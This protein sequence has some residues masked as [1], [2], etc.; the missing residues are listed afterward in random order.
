MRINNKNSFSVCYIYACCISECNQDPK[1]KKNTDKERKKRRYLNDMQFFF[2]F[3]LSPHLT[4]WNFSSRHSF[5]IFGFWLELMQRVN[6]FKMTLFLSEFWVRKNESIEWSQFFKV[7]V[8]C[9]VIYNF[10]V[11]KRL[12]RFFFF[13][14]L[15]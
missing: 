14:N 10:F 15:F 8:L 7:Q 13:Q 5:S 1:K 4:A 9:F 11:F 2:Q 12:T 6:S 3:Y